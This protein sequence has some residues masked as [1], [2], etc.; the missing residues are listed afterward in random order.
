[1]TKLNKKVATVSSDKVKTYKLP[2]GNMVSVGSERFCC[3]EVLSQS[4]LANKEALRIQDTTFQSIRKSDVDICKDPYANLVFSGGTLIYELASAW[5][6]LDG[7][8][9]HSSIFGHQGCNFPAELAHRLA[10]WSLPGRLRRHG[11]LCLL[12]SCGNH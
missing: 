5:P 7:L 12:E 4:S 9:W 3:P 10:Q 8:L 6:L 2:D 1:M 11:R